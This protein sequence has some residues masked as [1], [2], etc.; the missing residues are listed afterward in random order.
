MQVEHETG[1]V[2]HANRKMKLS[3]RV[4]QNATLVEVT[5][6]GNPAA[7]YRWG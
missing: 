6:Q 5:D 1:F 3:A 2:H 7:A 4:I